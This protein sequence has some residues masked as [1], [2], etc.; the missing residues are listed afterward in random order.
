MKRIVGWSIGCLG[1]CLLVGA[2]CG[3]DPAQE[4]SVRARNLAS[5]EIQTF[6][7]EGDIPA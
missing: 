2:G 4:G 6:S 7:S 5:G 3:R 1:M